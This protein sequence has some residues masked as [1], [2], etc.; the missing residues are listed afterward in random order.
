MDRHLSVA[1]TKL[2][3]TAIC[4]NTGWFVKIKDTSNGSKMFQDA[5]NPDFYVKIYQMKL[6]GEWCSTYIKF[7]Y[8]IGKKWADFKIT[9]KPLPDDSKIAAR[10]VACRTMINSI[11]KTQTPDKEDP[12]LIEEAS[13][14]V[15]S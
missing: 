4:I 12:I 10:E 9:Y 13:D 7:V 11:H 8:H 1:F 14:G 2:I 15:K 5:G 6:D 3:E